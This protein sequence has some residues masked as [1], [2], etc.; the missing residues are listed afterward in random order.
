MRRKK[1]TN[2]EERAS[3]GFDQLPA[4]SDFYTGAPSE[5]PLYQDKPLAESLRV[6]KT[7][8]HQAVAGRRKEAIDPREK[9]ALLAILK[10]VIMI[11]LLVIAFFMLRK[12]IKL[13]E[14]SVWMDTQTEVATSPVLLEVE[15]IEEFDIENKDARELFAE[16]IEGWKEADRLVRSADALLKRNNFDRAISQCQDALRISPSH[17]GA[18]EHLGELYF[19]KGMIVESINSYIRLLSVDP[20]RDDLLEKLIKALDTHGDAPAVAY[21]AQWFLEENN[22]DE[23]VQYYLANALFA[24]EDYSDAVDAYKRVLRDSPGD[25]LALEKLAIAYMTLD[26]YEEALGA[27]EQLRE[28]NYRD[29]NYYR[30]IAICNAQLGKS[31]ET[32]QTLGK[33]AHLFGQNIVVGWIQDPKLDPIREDR[34]FQAFADRVGGEEFRLWLEKVAKTMDG[35]ER[36]DIAP[37][38][39]LP[40]GNQLQPDLL[41]PRK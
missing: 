22:Y 1:S 17:M 32:V 5:K 6:R 37:Q 28:S 4:E 38:L 10:S 3:S 19:E 21:M 25:V 7:G 30:K 2:N 24:Q 23:D 15:L 34:S 27:L 26:D 41:K 16:R 8:R 36:E 18:L 12:G 29:Q 31:A 20:S 33:A 14:E 39:T 11:L 40:E 35:E 13:Y 9:M